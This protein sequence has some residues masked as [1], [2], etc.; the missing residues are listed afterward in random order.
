MHGARKTAQLKRFFTLTSSLNS[1]GVFLRTKKF[2]PAT[3]A[4]GVKHSTPLFGEEQRARVR[5]G[6]TARY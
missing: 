2:A 3:R 6:S 5:T 1:C 4:Q